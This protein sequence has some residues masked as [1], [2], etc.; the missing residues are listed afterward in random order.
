MW[1]HCSTDWF[2]KITRKAP[3][4]GSFSCPVPGRPYCAPAPG[5]QRDAGGVPPLANCAPAL[6]NR[7]RVR[8]FHSDKE[9]NG[10]PDTGPLP[11]QA[12]GRKPVVFSQAKRGTAVP[13]RDRCRARQQNQGRLFSP[14]QR[15]ERPSRHGTSRTE[16]VFIQ[17]KQSTPAEFSAGV[18]IFSQAGWVQSGKEGSLVQRE[19][20]ASAD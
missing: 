10:R 13:P 7:T 14:R 3:P 16:P 9:R 6:D 19:L 15:E 2:N 20:S 8:C 4:K 17:S 18:P 1:V 11:R 12:I 5:K